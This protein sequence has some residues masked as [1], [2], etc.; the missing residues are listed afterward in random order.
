MSNEYE[1]KKQFRIPTLR[2]SSV[3]DIQMTRSQW[4]IY[5]PYVWKQAI[6]GAGQSG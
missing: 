1:K 2:V 6:T 4:R 5:C 3:T